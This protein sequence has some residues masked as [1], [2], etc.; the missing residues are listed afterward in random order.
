MPV[1]LASPNLQNSAEEKENKCIVPSSDTAS[2]PLSTSVSVHDFKMENPSFLSSHKQFEAS[3][4]VKSKTNELQQ[5]KGT[6][7]SV[8]LIRI[9]FKQSFL[10][11]VLNSIKYFII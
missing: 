6:K 3:K 8:I 10:F 9:Y 7:K 11:F 1:S 2:F 5:K 4:P